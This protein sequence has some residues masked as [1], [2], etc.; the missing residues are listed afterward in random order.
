MKAKV[1]S[2]TSGGEA[3][4]KNAS[5]YVSGELA[6]GYLKA[7]AGVH[8]L[9]RKSPFN[10]KNLRQ[11][12][13]ALVEVTPEVTDKEIEIK[14]EDIKIDT[15]RASGHGGQSVN[16]TDSAVRITYLPAKISVS[17]QNER[18]QL[19]NKQTAMKI[20]KSKIAKIKE[21]QKEQEIENIQ[22]EV[23]TAKW[24]NQIRSYVFD[25]YRLVKDHRTNYE[26]KNVGK[27]LDGDIK[28]FIES[29]LKK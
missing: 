7:E 20:L 11:T 21:E 10:S 28:Q 1:L 29:F 9:V 6:Y 3:G 13:F 19:Q 22:G 4:I 2:K 27:V 5:L 15:F 12:S 25:P 23:K 16:T 17:C 14:D 8:R 18:S 24:G 26:E